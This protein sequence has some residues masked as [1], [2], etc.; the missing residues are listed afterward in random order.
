[1]ILKQLNMKKLIFT[2]LLIFPLS[3]ALAQDEESGGDYNWTVFTDATQFEYVSGDDFSSGVLGLGVFYNISEKLQAGASFA[4]VF[5][6]LEGDAAFNVAA[7]YFAFGN[8]YVQAGLPLTDAAG[9][10][11]NIGIGNRINIGDRIE[12]LPS[13]NYNTVEGAFTIGTGFAI[14]L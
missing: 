12:F 11:V 9:S 8:V 7:R 14:K 2:L 5:G 13:L 10:G 3:T 4:T 6:D 1:M